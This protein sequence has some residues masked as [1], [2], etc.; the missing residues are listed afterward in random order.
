MPWKTCVYI[1]WA[2]SDPEMKNSTNTQIED[3][4]NFLDQRTFRKCGSLHISDL[5]TLSCFSLRLFAY[6]NFFADL[7]LLQI[8]KYI[9]SPY[10]CSSYTIKS[11]VAK[12]S[13]R[14]VYDFVLKG[15]KRYKLFKRYVISP[16]NG[17]N[18]RFSI[19]GLAHLRN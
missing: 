5:R 15:P 6:P 12:T 7:G 14:I 2:N 17:E 18:L 8:H 1:S 16:S 10:K 13:D 9:S 19:S 11:C 4:E 3:L